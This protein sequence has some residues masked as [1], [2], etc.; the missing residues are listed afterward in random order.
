ML[1][2]S[3][4]NRFW[5]R[6]PALSRGL[7]KSVFQ[8]SMQSSFACLYRPKQASLLRKIKTRLKC[9]N[10]LTTF[11]VNDDDVVYSVW[12]LTLSALDVEPDVIL[13]VPCK[14]GNGQEVQP[15]TCG[16]FM[17]KQMLSVNKATQCSIQNNVLHVE[18]FK[19][20]R[21]RTNK[22]PSCFQAI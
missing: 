10:G 4:T 22:R 9:C 19:K 7:G 11:E 13:S 1:H 18:T 20:S 3:N 15:Q 2:E 8:T 5:F 14:P 17:D 16:V 6:P 21:D 12:F